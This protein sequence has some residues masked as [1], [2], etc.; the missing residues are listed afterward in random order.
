MLTVTHFL[1]TAKGSVLQHKATGRKKG[2]GK[3]SPLPF[4]KWHETEIFCPGNCLK[5]CM[6]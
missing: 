2:Q 1:L 6:V 3:V 5:Q 4:H